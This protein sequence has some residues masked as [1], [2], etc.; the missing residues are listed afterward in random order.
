VRDV[1]SAVQMMKPAPSSGLPVVVA[2]EA[3]EDLAPGNLPF[4]TAGDGTVRRVQL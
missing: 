3:A 4:G 1:D 2:D